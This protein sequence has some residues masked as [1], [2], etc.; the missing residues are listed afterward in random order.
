MHNPPVTPLPLFYSV[1]K[2]QHFMN[3]IFLERALKL[4]YVDI[5]S[6]HNYTQNLNQLK[7]FK[8]NLFT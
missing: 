4:C 5:N 1:L 6:K 8:D 7:S 2:I 3:N